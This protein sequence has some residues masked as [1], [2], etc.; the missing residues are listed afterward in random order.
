MGDALGER[1]AGEA[2]GCSGGWGG[3]HP[4]VSLRSTA[5]F[6][7]RYAFSGGSARA[8]LDHR[9]KSAPRAGCAY[10]VGADVGNV[11]GVV[12]VGVEESGEGGRQL[13][14]YG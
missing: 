13:G 3:R 5:R 1:Y 14:I 10:S 2:C 7:V 6:P 4:V 11:L 12:A 8:S 9:H